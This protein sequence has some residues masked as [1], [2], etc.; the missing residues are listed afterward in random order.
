MAWRNVMVKQLWKN[1]RKKNNILYEKKVLPSLGISS[2][3]VVVKSVGLLR[4]VEALGDVVSR[5]AELLRL[6]A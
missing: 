4:Q 2:P 1:F 5:L 3:G 6:V